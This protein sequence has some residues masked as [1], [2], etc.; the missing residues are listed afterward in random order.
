MGH[1]LVAF[2]ETPTL[3]DQNSLVISTIFQN[4]PPKMVTRCER[5]A[6]TLAEIR[7]EV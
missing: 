3:P 2:T 6:A 4:L 7:G 1:K 5:C